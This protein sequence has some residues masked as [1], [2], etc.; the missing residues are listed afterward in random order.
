M[1]RISNIER[2]FLQ[3][4]KITKTKNIFKKI[5]K[6]LQI[7]S[8]HVN[9][10]NVKSN[11]QLIRIVKNII[12]NND[13][14]YNNIVKIKYVSML[15]SLCSN[16][17]N[18]NNKLLDIYLKQKIKNI[19]NELNTSNININKDINDNYEIQINDNYKL[20]YNRKNIIKSTKNIYLLYD[21]INNI[22]IINKYIQN[23]IDKIT[24]S[25]IINTVIPEELHIKVDNNIKGLI[26]D[27]IG[28]DI[29]QY[30]INKFITKNINYITPNQIILIKNILNESYDIEMQIFN[31]N[32][33]I[34]QEIQELI[35]NH[36][37]CLINNK[38]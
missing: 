16:V 6:Q 31:I 14:K 12:N 25:N 8:T 18:Y 1:V 2:K 30:E 33:D 26:N 5:I 19:K 24:L 10:S 3:S 35:N 21:I 4:I 32:N 13:V 27:T 9:E 23:E 22:S 11:L 36:I 17:N 28:I 7:K 38:N 29:R 15:Y 34:Y 37:S 20:L